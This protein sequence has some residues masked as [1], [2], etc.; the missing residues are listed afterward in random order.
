MTGTFLV[1]AFSQDSLKKLQMLKIHPF[2]FHTWSGLTSGIALR[3]K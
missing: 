2:V 3:T 1:N